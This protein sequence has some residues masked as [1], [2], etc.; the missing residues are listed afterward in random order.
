LATNGKFPES[1][2]LTDLTGPDRSGA[3]ALGPVGDSLDDLE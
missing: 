1:H 2:N 3:P